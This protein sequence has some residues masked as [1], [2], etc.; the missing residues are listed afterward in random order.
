MV[1]CLF[2]ARLTATVSYR[3]HY[4]LRVCKEKKSE[5]NCCFCLFAKQK[6]DVHFIF[7]ENINLFNTN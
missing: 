3:S 1:K 5:Q 2:T 7:D 6:E 4:L